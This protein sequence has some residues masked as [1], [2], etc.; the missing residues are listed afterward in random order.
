MESELL[1]VMLSWDKTGSYEVSDFADDGEAGTGDD[2]MTTL[3]QSSLFQH[4]PPGNIQAI[5]LRLERRPVNAGDII[6][7]QGDF[8][9]Y[10][11]FLIEGTA[12]VKRESPHG[13]AGGFALARLGKGD[14]FGEEALISGRERTASVIMQTDGVVMRL[15]QEDFQQLLCEP[16]LDYVSYDDG[17]RIVE[18]GGRWLD[19]R[20]PNEVSGVTLENAITMPLFMVRMKYRTLDQDQRLVV[21]CDD[22][23]RAA[24]AAYLLTERGFKA[25]VVKGGLKS[26]SL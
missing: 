25:S 14:T 4:I 18:N 24:A 11:Y 7:R 1:E 23:G 15:G 9:D 20:L 22:G 8:G 21:A 3:L 10:F 5:F 2:W 16:M 17:K 12:M 6:V 19:V 13:P 26:V